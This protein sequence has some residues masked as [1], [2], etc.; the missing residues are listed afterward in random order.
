MGM[1][2]DFFAAGPA[3]I[4][5]LLVG[6]LV[7]GAAC[8]ALLVF[9]LYWRG[10]AYQ[11]R[12]ERDLAIAQGDVLAAGIESCNAGVE[13]AHSVAGAAVDQMRKL[14]DQARKQ[15]AGARAQVARIEDL[16]KQPVPAGAGCDEAWELL[17]K[18]W[19]ARAPR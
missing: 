11:A 2:L 13:L 3:R 5:G 16:L 4:K 8:L 17:E 15:A 6:A 19:K 9:G 7:A 10:E 12:G 18:D 14:V 1:L